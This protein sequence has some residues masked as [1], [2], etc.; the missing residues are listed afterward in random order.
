MFLVS[1]LSTSRRR[2]ER[3]KRLSKKRKHKQKQHPCW[4]LMQDTDLPKGMPVER[5]DGGVIY[6]R[7]IRWC[8]KTLLIC[9]VQYPTHCWGSPWV[10]YW[11]PGNSRNYLC[12]VLIHVLWLFS[13]KGEWAVVYQETVYKVSLDLLIRRPRRNRFDCRFGI[14]YVM[15]M[16]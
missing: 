16:R 3:V 13:E 11:S 4:K 14:P 1:L 8:C 5:S 6:T 12:C 2:F 15:S 7:D 10:S 9:I